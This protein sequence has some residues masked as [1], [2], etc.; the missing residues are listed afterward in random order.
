MDINTEIKTS[1][2]SYRIEPKLEGGFVAK[3]DE[4]GLPNIE[5]ATREEVQQKIQSAITEMI[6]NQVP[7]TFK[8]GNLNIKVNRKVNFTT[9]TIT[10]SSAAGDQSPSAGARSALPTNTA[11]IVPERNLGTVLWIVIALLILD[12]FVYFFYLHK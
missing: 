3:P 5:G 12:A 11:P 10:N 2:F 4:P 6:G 9:R 7:M 1:T 8:L